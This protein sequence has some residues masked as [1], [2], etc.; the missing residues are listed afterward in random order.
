M[1]KAYIKVKALADRNKRYT[2]PT[3]LL[4]FPTSLPKKSLE[5]QSQEHPNGSINDVTGLWH[6][7]TSVWVKIINTNISHTQ[8]T[9]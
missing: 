4:A 2:I 9:T 6:A 1:I 8:K 5:I 3:Q 7:V